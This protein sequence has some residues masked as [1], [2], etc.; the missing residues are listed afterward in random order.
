MSA[1]T[2]R[3]LIPPQLVH[4]LDQPAHLAEV[5]LD[6]SA[7]LQFRVFAADREQLRRLADKLS[8]PDR[9]TTL[10]IQ[11]SEQFDLVPGYWVR[12]GSNGLALN[13]EIPPYNRYPITTLRVFLR[14]MGREVTKGLEE[15]LNPALDEPG[16]RWGITMDLDRGPSIFCR[17]P[18]VLLDSW[19]ERLVSFGLAD[20]TARSMVSRCR[21]MAG[22]PH[23]YV[24]LMPFGLD[25]E[26]ISLADLGLPLNQWPPLPEPLVCPYIKCTV[27]GWQAYLDWPAFAAWWK[28][29]YSRAADEPAK[30]LDRVQSYYDGA[31]ELYLA[32]VGRTWQAGHFGSSGSEASNLE[33][34]RRA[35]LKPRQNI[36]DAGCGV[37]G[38]ALDIARS[39]PE[40]KIIGITLCHAQQA[41]A[42]E[43]IQ[44]LGLQ[45][46]VTVRVGDYHQ[47]SEP[48]A[49]F[50]RVLYLESA[51]YAYD[52]VA[53]FKEAWRVLRPGGMVYV[54][55]VFRRPGPL[56]GGEWRELAAFDE[57]YAQ[58]TP[59][60]EAPR[61]S[62][63]IAGFSS[64]EA[65][66]VPQ[67][68]VTFQQALTTQFGRLHPT[69]FQV[70]PLFFG[71]LKAR[72]L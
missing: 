56:S 32:H 36:L 29:K 39:I 34:A 21:P 69:T 61:Q 35:E 19:L 11:I 7:A 49:S 16:S 51:G 23:C 38:P 15:A 12:I 33:I 67:N 9:L 8:W 62:L 24:S 68:M 40:L 27:D 70:L 54:K 1:D 57:L 48:D 53:L 22:S 65:T 42:Q 18:R 20:D 60:L 64:I 31:Q 46:L 10:A 55:D 28:P 5:R 17:V 66:E 72:K 26:K 71:E 52:P 2:V 14:K 6:S 37:A 25:L 43:E 41:E 44:R 58:R 59:T 50:D 3:Q 45:D 4:V 47:L 30:F 13:F 63:Q